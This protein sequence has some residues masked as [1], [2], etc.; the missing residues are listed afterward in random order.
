[1]VPEY[2]KLGYSIEILGQR[3]INDIDYVTLK[4]TKPDGTTS[5]FTIPIYIIEPKIYAGASFIGDQSNP[6]N[7]L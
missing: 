6:A 1:M 5:G 2:V 3:V 4:F 7:A